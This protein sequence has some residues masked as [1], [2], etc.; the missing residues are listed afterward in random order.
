MITNRSMPECTVVPEL[1]YVDVGE[2]VA[3][4]CGAFGFTV[5][6]TIANHRA[7]LNVGSGAVIVAE[8]RHDSGQ[9]ID[10]AHAVMVRV[11]DVDAHHARAAARGARVLQPPRT[12]VYGER[13]YTVQDVGGHVWTFSNR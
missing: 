12:Y 11:E 5:R 3:W 1:A 13:Q 7:Q 8:F 9:Q 6:L 10:R 4:L 2:A